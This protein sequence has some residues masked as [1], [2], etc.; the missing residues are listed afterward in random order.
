MLRITP[1]ATSG[2]M[3]R[4][5]LSWNSGTGMGENVKELVI[6]FADSGMLTIRLSPRPLLHERV[7]P[8]PVTGGQRLEFDRH[9]EAMWVEGQRDC[10]GLTTDSK[11]FLLLDLRGR[12][13]GDNP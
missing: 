7:K 13:G 2:L 1:S 5:E 3:L 8:S 10:N 4:L 11:D 9:W 6:L 12:A